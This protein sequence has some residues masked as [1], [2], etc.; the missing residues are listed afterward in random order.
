MDHFKVF[1]EFVTIVLLF[2]LGLGATRQAGSQIPNQG[3]NHIPYIGR[4]SLNRWTAKS[5][6]IL[7]K[8]RKVFQAQK[9]S[10]CTYPENRSMGLQP[11]QRTAR[12][13]GMRWGWEE[14][15]AD[16]EEGTL[17]TMFKRF[18]FTQE[19]GARLEKVRN[20]YLPHKMVIPRTQHR[21]I[22][23]KK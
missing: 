21:F 13:E 9:T 10:T 4:W 1:T 2:C 20:E 18:I 7:F 5:Q 14:G 3:S 6:D 15:G 17:N 11:G 16:P 19:Q 23:A 22:R 12:F 8:R